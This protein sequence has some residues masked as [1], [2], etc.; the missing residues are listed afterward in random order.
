MRLLEVVVSVVFLAI[1]CN[2]LIAI[3][4]PVLRNFKERQKL[5]KQCDCDKFIAKSF[6]KKCENAL[7][8]NDFSE[9]EKEVCSLCPVET[10]KVE[11]LYENNPLYLKAVWSFDGK[12]RECLGVLASRKV[13]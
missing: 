5:E 4:K 7:S 9:W 12:K 13:E 8:S 10:L 11:R 3:G 2:L 6:L 1:F